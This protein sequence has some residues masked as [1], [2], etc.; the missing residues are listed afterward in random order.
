MPKDAAA[1]K[2]IKQLEGAIRLISEH[3]S[4]MSSIMLKCSRAFET[5]IEKG[6]ITND[7]IQEAITE[8][9]NDSNTDSENS[10]GLQVQP[11]GSGSD[12]SDH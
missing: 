7:E 1:R 4:K 11:E 12:E 3:M 5:L 6:I 2:R 10:N 8:E 9:G